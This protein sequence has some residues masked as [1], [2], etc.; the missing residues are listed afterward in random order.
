MMVSSMFRGRAETQGGNESGNR[1]FHLPLAIELAAARI[2]LLPE[3][4]LLQRLEQRL[5]LLSGGPVTCRRA[6][7]RCGPRSTGA[8]TYCPRRSSGCSPAW[9]CSP[10]GA[11]WRRS[12]R[13]ATPKSISMCRMSGLAR[14]Q[15]P[16]PPGGGEGDHPLRDS[17]GE[18]PSL[19]T[20]AGAIGLR[21]FVARSAGGSRAGSDRASPCPA[22]A[23]HESASVAPVTEAGGLAGGRAVQPL[24]GIWLDGARF[25]VFFTA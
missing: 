3:R 12:R 1:E 17:D 7:R 23:R 19:T 16:A 9:P 22:A 10:A 2:K 20:L 13:S 14:R 5:K 15:E 25:L 11:A 6:S 21:S 4:A 24:R 18:H 8:T